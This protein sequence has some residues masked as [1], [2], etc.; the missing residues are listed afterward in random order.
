MREENTSYRFGTTTIAKVKAAAELRPFLAESILDSGTVVVKPNWISTDPGEFTDSSTM[1]L[2]FEALDSRIVVVES[3]C[4][5]RSLNLLEKGKRFMAGEK[6]VDWYWLLK[7]EGWNWLIENPDWDW[8]KRDGHWEHIREEEAAFL[9]RYGFAD[10]FQ[11]FDVNY[12]NVTEEVWQGRVADPIEVKQKVESRF[13]PVRE[14]QLY[15]LIPQSLYDLRGSPFISLARLKMYASFTFK[16]IFG[17]IPDP[18][19][20]W[21]H[22][23]SNNRV[24]ANIVDINKIYH[25]LFRVYGICEALKSMPYMNPDGRYRNVFTGNY[26]IAEGEGVVAVGEDL[27]TLDALLLALSDPSKRLIEDNVNRAPLDQA[28]AEFGA[29]DREAIEEAAQLVGDWITPK[30]SS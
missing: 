18:L 6:E 9:E 15:H 27:V 28:E 19:R 20:S 5:A 4:L 24:T 1:R 10:L 22:G 8:F 3:Y 11:E 2:L 12:I 13:K 29:V 14:E 23:P 17:M 16:N 26:D 25:T 21:W 7:G 30:I